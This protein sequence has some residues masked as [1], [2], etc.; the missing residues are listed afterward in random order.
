[1]TTTKISPAR[2]TRGARISTP[3]DEDAPALAQIAQHAA[4]AL[5]DATAPDVGYPGLT[6][7]EDV[8]EVLAA[9]AALA[10]GLQRTLAHLGRFLDEELDAGRLTGTGQD[11]G[12]AA[13]AAT[14]AQ[15][16]EAHADAGRLS[17]ELAAAGAAVTGTTGA[18]G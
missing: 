15:L 14:R 9:L 7:P 8:A 10:G 16:L 11:T 13:V 17:A 6:H 3:V 12:A 4:K 2:A 5:D 1:M 18:Y